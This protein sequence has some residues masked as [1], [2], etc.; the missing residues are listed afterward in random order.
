MLLSGLED[1]SPTLNNG[2]HFPQLSSTDVK[3]AFTNSARKGSLAQD[4]SKVDVD[5]DM[6][7]LLE[8]SGDE[9]LYSSK[10]NMIR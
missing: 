10:K 1:P 4:S 8:D 2:G 9:K 5:M 3:N 7:D 6:F